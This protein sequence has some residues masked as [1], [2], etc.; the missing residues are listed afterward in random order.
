MNNLITK[1]GNSPEI[2]MLA[3]KLKRFEEAQWVVA[4]GKSESFN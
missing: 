3:D 1:I 2:R 4:G